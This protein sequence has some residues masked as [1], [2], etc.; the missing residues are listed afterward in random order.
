MSSPIL[1]ERPSVLYWRRPIRFGTFSP[2]EPKLLLHRLDDREP[3]TADRFD[4]LCLSF[5]RTTH[6]GVRRA[7]QFSFSWLSSNTLISE[8]LGCRSEATSLTRSPARSRA[9]APR[10]GFLSGL[11]R[12]IPDVVLRA[13]FCPGCS[14]PEESPPPLARRP[15]PLP[16]HCRAHWAAKPRS[17]SQPQRPKSPVVRSDCDVHIRG[18]QTAAP[19]TPLA[20]GGDGARSVLR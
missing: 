17:V 12:Q 19:H 20:C 1:W 16:I 5:L 4:R 15:Q 6:S 18:G 10:V 11:P 8:A 13:P 7:I 14:G 2:E 9:L 3:T